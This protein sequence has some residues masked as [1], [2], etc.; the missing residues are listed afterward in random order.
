[1]RT[2]RPTGRQWLALLAV[3]GAALLVAQIGKSPAGAAPDSG[4][5]QGVADA[6]AMATSSTGGASGRLAALT[7]VTDAML[8][9]P[10]PADWLMWRAS[11]DSWGFSPLDQIDA[12]NVGRLSLVWT[13][14]LAPGPQEGTPL[15]HDGVLYF[16]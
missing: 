11:L 5:A 14:D 15:V 16:P 10:P 6:S 1:M 12:G 7:P 2:P 13:R 8:A 3:A 4:V 9:A